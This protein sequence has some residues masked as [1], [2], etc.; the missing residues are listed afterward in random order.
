MWAFMG[1][2]IT[3]VLGHWLLFYG[4]LAQPTLILVVLGYGLGGLYYF[5]HH[6]RLSRIIKLEFAFIVVAIL[7]INLIALEI[8]SSSS[9]II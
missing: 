3:W 2:A 1:V 7:V 4:I 5:D 8:S 9:S 6:D